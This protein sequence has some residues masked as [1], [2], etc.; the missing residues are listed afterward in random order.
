MY[1]AK[2]VLDTANQIQCYSTKMETLLSITA[3]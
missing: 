3:I 1:N 2:N